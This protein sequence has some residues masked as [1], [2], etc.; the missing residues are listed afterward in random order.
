[1]GTV[2]LVAAS[3]T[4]MLTETL[5]RRSAFAAEVVRRISAAKSLHS[6]GS[7]SGMKVDEK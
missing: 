4:S 2:T 7:A 1:M 6:C 5:L 3:R